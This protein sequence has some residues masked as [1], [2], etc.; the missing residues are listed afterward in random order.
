LSLKY[1]LADLSLDLKIAFIIKMD[2][3]PDLITGKPG[4]SA[5]SPIGS[6]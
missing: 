2:Q 3:V 4:K 5:P 6:A 1:F